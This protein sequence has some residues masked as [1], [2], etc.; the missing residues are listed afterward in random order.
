M[1]V[2]EAVDKI[3]GLDVDQARYIL[4]QHGMWLRVMQKDGE[5]LMGTC[6]FR[7]D[8]LNV[9][10]EDGKVIGLLQVG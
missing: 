2:A 10:V 7:S 3:I 4:Q 5:H 8:R 9:A 1:T 6:D